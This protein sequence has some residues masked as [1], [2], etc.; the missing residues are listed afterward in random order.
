MNITSSNPDF[1]RRDSKDSMCG[2]LKD[3]AAPMLLYSP[4][5][6]E[7]DQSLSGDI[8]SIVVSSHTNQRMVENFSQ[9]SKPS[10]LNPDPNSVKD[11]RT[12]CSY[13]VNVTAMVNTAYITLGRLV[14]Q[15]G[16]GR[17]NITVRDKIHQ[18]SST[19]N[20][21]IGSTKLLF[22][23]VRGFNLVDGTERDSWIKLK[24]DFKGTVQSYHDMQELVARK[25]KQAPPLASQKAAMEDLLRWNDSSDEEEQL[26]V[27]EKVNQ[28]GGLHG[29]NSF[30]NEHNNRILQMEADIVDVNEVFN[31][32]PNVQPSKVS[33]VP[34]SESTPLLQSNSSEIRVSGS[35]RISR[36]VKIGLVITCLFLIIIFVAVLLLVLVF[37]F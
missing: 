10:D 37:H 12:A 17:D 33:C 19:T 22:E 32:T 14:K 4:I 11:F 18:T 15:I 21:L 24:D 31:E 2:S 5:G 20:T 35:S 30:V 3:N 26:E 7:S 6:Y 28:I 27:R 36:K 1:E 13:L 16:T 34:A 9:I 29:E 25:M 8:P 23:K